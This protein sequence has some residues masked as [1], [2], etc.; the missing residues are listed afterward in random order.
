VITSV[1][2]RAPA[3]RHR[4]GRAE[5]GRRGR[6]HNAASAIT[7]LTYRITTTGEIVTKDELRDR[8]AAE[9]DAIGPETGAAS[10]DGKVDDLIADSMLAG[11]YVILDE[12]AGWAVTALLNPVRRLGCGFPTFT[13]GSSVIFSIRPAQL[14]RRASVPHPGYAPVNFAGGF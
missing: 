7:A 1:L 5:S 10:C 9:L 4:G 11:I 2:R 8:L 3:G 6:R 13:L 14:L 12:H